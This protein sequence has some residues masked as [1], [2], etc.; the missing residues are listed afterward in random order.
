MSFAL[1]EEQKLFR[2]SVNRF[3]TERYRFDESRASI[4]AHYCVD[5]NNWHYFRDQGWLA[6]PLPEEFGG[7]GGSAIDLGIL[8]EA[9]GC[10]PVLEPYVPA[11]VV[12]GGLI[13]MLG[14]HEQKRRF[15][16]PIADGAMIVALAHTERSAG[17]VI[18]SVSTRARRGPDGW[19]LDGKKTAIMGGYAANHLIVSARVEGKDR[20]RGGIGLFLVG[21]GAPGLTRVNY[22]TL[23]GGCG[24]DVILSS[25]AIPTDALLNGSTDAL[26]AL[27]LAYDHANAA[28]CAQTV[29]SAQM[30]VDMTLNHT[31]M[32]FQFGKPLAANQ[33]IRHR[34]VD[35]SIAC[36]E[37]R[38]A[39]LHAALS[40]ADEPI[41]RS[42]AVS[43]A[44]WKVATSARFIA[45]QAVQLHGAMGCTEE[46][47][48]GRYYKSILAFEVLFGSPD[49]HL[50]RHA[51][52][53]NAAQ[54][55]EISMGSVQ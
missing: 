38:A 30:I 46:L 5:R 11:V 52:L 16:L 47:A 24:S 35:M 41:F 55:M 32:R 2:D 19:I 42:R 54:N 53:R 43:S 40:L 44:K 22:P 49:R 36:I 9:F 12:A 7:L 14:T 17:E 34:L 29:G 48:L 6:L 10:G 37:A 28:L 31:R 15:L 23:D 13:A 33:V 21:S 26:S 3:V 8:M 25:V 27:E 18:E 20:D 50:R 45:E 51:M 1:S 4:V 39:A